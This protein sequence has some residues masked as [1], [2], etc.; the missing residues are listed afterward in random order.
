[1]PS[2][3]PRGRGSRWRGCWRTSRRRVP[4]MWRRCGGCSARY[5]RR[6]RALMVRRRCA[7]GGGSR[8]GRRR[9]RRAGTRLPSGPSGRRRRRTGG[10]GGA[11]AF[12]R[13]QREP[14][15]WRGR[16]CTIRCRA[17]AARPAPSRWPRS[18]RR[19]C[20]GPASISRPRPRWRR[21]RSRCWPIGVSARC[22][23]CRRPRPRGP[24]R[25]SV[26]AGTRCSRWPPWPCCSSGDGG[27]WAARRALGTV[28]GRRSLTRGR[29]TREGWTRERW[30]RL[31][32]ST[33]STCPP[34]RRMRDSTLRS[35]MRG[36]RRGRRPR[37]ASRSKPRS[38][39][40][41]SGTPIEPV[42]RSGRVGERAASCREGLRAGPRV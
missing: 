39:V 34:P 3:C 13:C 38:E 22:P 32:R 7:G 23:I 16:R 12:G 27:W 29:R 42:G 21:W 20:G 2:G 41:A 17:I 15:R 37:H 40:V 11:R 31:G 14:Q 6:W 36:R 24:S 10:R 8:P 30:M 25:P 26:V 4:G 18:R 9:R 28:G 19:R 33:G 1:M 5:R 35:S